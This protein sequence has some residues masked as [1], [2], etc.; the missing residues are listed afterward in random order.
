L[1]VLL[2]IMFALGGALV[3]DSYVFK[4]ACEEA[5]SRLETA[6]TEHSR[7]PISE[8]GNDKA[9]FTKEDVQKVMGF[10]PTKSE[11]VE[12]RYLKEYY[13]WW[14][15]LPLKRRYI[16]VV[17]AD[18]EGKRFNA[19]QIENE[20]GPESLPPKEIVTEVPAPTPPG[21]EGDEKPAGTEES[22]DDKKPET[23][24]DKSTD[25]K[26]PA[27][28]DKSTDDKK[29]ATDEKEEKTDKPGET[30]EEN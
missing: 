22:T 8:T 1:I 4:P 23:T 29:S 17:Y 2:L 10:G 3:V 27:A 7:K 11:I 15:P 26:K 9:Y 12:D 24:D 5:F 21:G 14:G 6:A 20:V 25:D 30:T 16:T 13:C 19:H 18:K 28:D